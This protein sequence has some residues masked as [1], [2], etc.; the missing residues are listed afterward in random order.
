MERWGRGVGQPRQERLGGCRR[1]LPQYG[2]Y[3]AVDTDRGKVEAA[4]ERR[5]GIIVESARTADCVYINGRQITN[6]LK[7]IRPVA[8]R[9]D[10]PGGR[11]FSLDIDWL[12]DEPVPDGW[13]PFLHFVDAEG[14]IVFQTGHNPPK[15]DGKSTGTLQATT[16]GSVPNNLGPGTELELWVGLYEPGNGK[17]LW[18]DGP[19]DNEARIRLGKIRLEGQDGQVTS[20]RLD[21]AGERAAG[22]ANPGSTPKAKP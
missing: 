14:K 6:G 15:F 20:H 21:A 8:R 18:I 22:T 12:A 1:V 19:I 7:P 9:F 3:A 16:R 10:S 2:F 17:R 4:I 13:V 11:E 5:E